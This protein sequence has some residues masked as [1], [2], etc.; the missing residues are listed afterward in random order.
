M[1]CT[2]DYKFERTMVLVSRAIF[3]VYKKEMFQAARYFN[4]ASIAG[5][6]WKCQITKQ[7]PIVHPEA[8]AHR[9]RLC[10][11]LSHY[12]ALSR[13]ES[14]TTKIGLLRSLYEMLLCKTVEEPPDSGC[15]LF[16]QHLTV[17][18]LKGG[19]IYFMDV[20]RDL[21]KAA[22]CAFHA[23]EV[24]PYSAVAGLCIA[25]PGTVPR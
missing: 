23:T 22:A 6:N 10:L 19:A 5:G 24:R 11:A 1:V 25:E 3:Y 2:S 16:Q 15:I 21:E 18:I 12:D 9:A 7:V 4:A 13:L 20:E 17:E 8:N 14:G